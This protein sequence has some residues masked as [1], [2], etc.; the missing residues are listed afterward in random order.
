MRPFL[1]I[2]SCILTS[3]V[4][5]QNLSDKYLHFKT[6][7][8][9]DSILYK[10]EQSYYFEIKNGKIIEKNYPVLLYMF[11]DKISDTPFLTKDSVERSSSSIEPYKYVKKRDFIFL[12]YYNYEKNKHKLNKEY[13]LRLYDTV[14]D[15]ANKNSLDSKNGISVGGASTYLG[16]IKIELNGKQFNT[17]RF[18]EDHD[19]GGSHPSYSTVEVFLEKETLIPIKFVTILYDYKTRERK[20]YSYVTVLTSSGNTLPDYTN[21]TTE[22]LILFE[23][24][25]VVW[26][27]KQRQ[28]F[29]KRFPPDMKFYGNC[30][31]KKLDGQISY[32]NYERNMYFKKL[33]VSK[34]CE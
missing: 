25:D 3:F 1:S 15:F 4:F 16:K 34:E 6:D 22:D 2:L 5:G 33:I 8:Y 30:V 21:K 32:F 18:L 19:E 9:W 24:K 27:E 26:T 23:N 28:E 20:L 31:L 13:S 10:S 7:Y 29:L 17:F 12:Q 11:T 14:F